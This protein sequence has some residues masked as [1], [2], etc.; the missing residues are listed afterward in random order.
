VISRLSGDS[1]RNIEVLMEEDEDSMQQDL[2]APQHK[3]NLWPDDLR[4]ALQILH[5]KVALKSIATVPFMSAIIASDV[6]FSGTCHVDNFARCV[7][8]VGISKVRAMIL[9]SLSCC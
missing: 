1:D 4:M 7:A 3:P 9:L 5:S 8:S 6:A 2:D